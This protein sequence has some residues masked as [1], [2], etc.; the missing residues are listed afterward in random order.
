MARGRLLR[1]RRP[2]RTAADR[3]QKKWW[4]LRGLLIDDGGW[5][6]NGRPCTEPSQTGVPYGLIVP[7]M[8]STICHIVSHLVSFLSFRLCVRRRIGDGHPFARGRCIF[9]MH[10]WQETI[11]REKKME[12]NR[13]IFSREKREQRT[14]CAVVAACVRGSML[15]LNFGLEVKTGL[16]ISEREFYL[17]CVKMYIKWW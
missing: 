12:K 16:I 11:G 14:K 15:Y 1:M 17:E 8:R 7:P 10:F 3:G 5:W 4:T 2:G 9:R 6:H 13:F